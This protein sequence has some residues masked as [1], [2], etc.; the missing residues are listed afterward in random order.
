MTE[1]NIH[2]IIDILREKAE[3]VSF[4]KPKYKEQHLAIRMDPERSMWSSGLFPDGMPPVHEVYEG[5]SDFRGPLSD[6]IA[7]G[8]NACRGVP[9]E[10]LR[11][12]LMAELRVRVSELEGDKKRLQEALARYADDE[13]RYN[14]GEGEPYGSIPIECGFVARQARFF[15]KA[16]K[17]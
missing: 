11:P 17:Q 6:R 14:R 4:P 9:T 8:F 3:L 7:A 5:V 15:I 16:D 12:D 2:K 1:V 13:D 10:D